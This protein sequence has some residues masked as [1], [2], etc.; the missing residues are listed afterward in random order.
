MMAMSE[1]QRKHN[2]AEDKKEEKVEESERSQRAPIVTVFQEWATDSSEMTSEHL[3]GLVEELEKLNESNFSI[4]QLVEVWQ[5]FVEK[6]YSSNIKITL[7]R[8]ISAVMLAKQ[9]NH[10][11]WQEFPKL[12]VTKLDTKEDFI[13]VDIRDSIDEIE[14]FRALITQLINQLDAYKQK[15]SIDMSTGKEDLQDGVLQESTDVRA[16]LIDN[17]KNALTIIDAK[18]YRRI[19]RHKMTGK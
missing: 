17:F 10:P 2:P 8:V 7:A 4:E 12:I 18:L 11:S 19:F 14:S 16:Q 13:P 6:N 9:A 3:L 1:D 5:S 15:N